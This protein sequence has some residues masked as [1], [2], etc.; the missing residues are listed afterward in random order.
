[1]TLKSLKFIVTVLNGIKFITKGPNILFA[2]HVRG[3]GKQFH[4]YYK[5]RSAP[6]WSCVICSVQIAAE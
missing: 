4:S 6:I 5:Q 3:L 2:L 1:M